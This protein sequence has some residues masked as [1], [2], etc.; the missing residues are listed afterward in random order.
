MSL[1]LTLDK[2]YTPHRW[3]T[4]QD[5]II[6][7]ATD[8][9]L[10]HLGEDIF[11]FHGGTNRDGVESVLV[12]SSIIVIDGAPN[13]RRYRDPAL[14]NSALFQRDRYVCAYCG[15]LF[16]SGELTRD[17]I[18]PTS[19]GGK[20]VWMN[21]VTACKKCNALKGDTL[22]DANLPFK[23]LGPQGTGKMNPLYVP[24]VPCK[25]EHMILKNRTV[26]FDQTRFLLERVKNRNSRIFQ[27][28]KDMF[29]E[30][31]SL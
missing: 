1:I 30:R 9:V 3:I 2:N 4:K 25:A 8:E 21:V 28:A 10:E 19:K 6:H 31:I 11:V 17:H 20:D 24:Y 27:Y 14:T 22:P 26:K 23:Q 13:A 18:H 7:E 15:G 5:A 16:R 12:T 29:G